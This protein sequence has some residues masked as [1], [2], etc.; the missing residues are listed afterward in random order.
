M[1]QS[2][3]AMFFSILAC[4][5]AAAA[6]APPDWV[7]ASNGYTRQLLD[8]Q[9]RHSPETGSQEGLV[10]YDLLVSD[11]SRADELVA[12]REYLAM[13]AKLKAAQLHETDK[14][15]LE[16]LEIL[17]K[18]LDL[19]FRQEDFAN[20]H[21]VPFVN[22]S[23]QVFAVLKVLLD[24][25]VA[26]QRRQASVERLRKYAGASP[27]FKPYAELLKA[28]RRSGTGRDRGCDLSV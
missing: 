9:L 12:R 14:K 27:G 23:Q 8:V 25:Q 22:A 21:L 7:A 28:L 6:A 26:P 16:D 2:F 20:Q 19:Q 3:I 17:R 13:L 1:R 5:A 15:V 4:A 24:D 11:P 10:Q 18:A